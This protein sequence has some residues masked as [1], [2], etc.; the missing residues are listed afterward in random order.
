MPVRLHPLPWLS[1]LII[2]ASVG[3]TGWVTAAVATTRSRASFS[4]LEMPP[5][6]PSPGVFASLSLLTLLLM[7]AGAVLVAYRTGNFRDASGPLGL[8]FTAQGVLTGWA[9]VFFGVGDI[10]LSL[11][12]LAVLFILVIAMG[13]DFLRFSRPA[14]WLQVPVALWIAFLAYLNAGIWGA[15][16]GG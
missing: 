9:L 5:L 2:A 15:N 14:A 10:A 4:R 8:F 3:L 16:P 13:R 7:T 12:V 11:G 6:V 1:F